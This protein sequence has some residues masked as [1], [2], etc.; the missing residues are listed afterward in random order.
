MH[1]TGIKGI[2]FYS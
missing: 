1:T 2:L